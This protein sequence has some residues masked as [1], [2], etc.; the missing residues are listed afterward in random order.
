MFKTRPRLKMKKFLFLFGT[1]PEAI[2]LAPLINKFK[3]RIEDYSIT[4]C[5]S[6]QHDEMLYQVLDIFGIKVDYDLKIMKKGQDLFD[7]TTDALNSIKLILESISPDYVFVHGDTSTTLCA[8][9]ASFYKKIK[10]CHVE[11][12]LRTNDIF[13]PFPEE[14]N[15]Q[16]V[17]KLAHFHFCP[18]PTSKKNLLNDGVSD[19]RISITGNTVIDALNYTT[20]KIL[21][22]D[23]F[24][25]QI[26]AKINSELDL[27]YESTKFVLI[28]GHRREN[29]G[30]GFQNICKAIKK[31][32]QNNPNIAF[33]YPVHLNP[34]VMSQS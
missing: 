27:D 16:V 31:L 13:S 18:T 22:N 12:G 21:G 4:V 1:R 8:S 10:L 17:S 29:F 7:V 28:T 3:E 23:L 20:E 5:S 33:V 14:F 9:I 30:T 24:R 34:N 15:R 32:S 11:A 19:E 25:D 26:K 6:G 2:K